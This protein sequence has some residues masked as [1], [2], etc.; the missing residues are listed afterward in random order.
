MDKPM[1]SALYRTTAEYADNSTVH[2]VKYIFEK[3][4]Y[5]VNKIN[6]HSIN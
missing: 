1:N 4:W 3:V 6:A 2:G 5:K